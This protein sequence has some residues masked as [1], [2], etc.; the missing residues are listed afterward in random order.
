MNDDTIKRRVS[1][2]DQARLVSGLV[3]ED[4]GRIHADAQGA[5]WEELRRLLPRAFAP[6]VVKPAGGEP[7]NDDQARV[8][9]NTKMPWG[10]Y[11]GTRVDE[12]P[13]DYLEKLCDPQ[14]FVKSLKRYVASQRIL[15]ENGDG[16]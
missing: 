2:R 3:V 8:F 5:F 13:L 7:F 16:Q 14:P 4:A 12:V 6:P 9:G 10:K 15:L 1:A 11:A